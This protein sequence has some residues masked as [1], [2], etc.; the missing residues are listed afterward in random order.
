MESFPREI[1][2]LPLDKISGL[3]KN[4]PGCHLSDIVQGLIENSI[5]SSADE[6]IISIVNG[7][8]SSIKV[9]DNG[10]G[11]P[12]S[13][14]P[15][16][17]SQNFS[18]RQEENENF[19]GFS[20]CFLSNISCA[21]RIKI[22]TRTRNDDRGSLSIYEFSR[23]IGFEER[24]DVRLGTTVEIENFLYNFP[25]QRKKARLNPK[26][27]NKMIDTIAKYAIAYSW[28]KF[29]V[30]I[31]SRYVL[32][33][34][35]HTDFFSTLTKLHHITDPLN[36]FKAFNFEISK[37]FH[38]IAFLSS[39][40]YTSQNLHNPLY[41]R[42]IFLNGRLVSIPTIK[43]PLN[44]W[45][46][47]FKSKINKTALKLPYFIFIK[48]PDDRFNGGF[49]LSENT[50]NSLKLFSSVDG[51][52]QTSKIIENQYFSQKYKTFDFADRLINECSHNLGESLNSQISEYQNSNDI[53]KF[54]S[55]LF[56]FHLKNP[57][58]N[59]DLNKLLYPQ[60]PQSHLSLGLVTTSQPSQSSSQQVIHPTPTLVQTARNQSSVP[61]TQFKPSPKIHNLQKPPMKHP[62]TPLPP[63]QLGNVP[64]KPTVLVPPQ[65]T[66]SVGSYTE[67][68]KSPL[69]RKVSM[70]SPVI[71]S[72]STEMGEPLRLAV[73]KSFPTST[74]NSNMASSNAKFT[75]IN[76]LLSDPAGSS[77]PIPKMPV[78]RIMNTSQTNSQ[79]LPRTI[80]N[81]QVPSNSGPIK[82]ITMVQSSAKTLVPIKRKII[83]VK[84]S[85]TAV[86]NTATN[87]SQDNN[88]N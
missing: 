20:G 17:C 60:V 50:F 34:N 16:V 56:Q 81:N 61:T 51:E 78:T 26:E 11:I 57:P 42:A 10:H 52:D 13:S 68:H 63:Q 82:P 3:K 32:R 71:H 28:I 45:Y 22:E 35:G 48:Y 65:T 67:P 73:P 29:E 33:T 74:S 77:K 59:I 49:C 39:P 9:E 24:P 62:P 53:R 85:N 8:F 88:N 38:A 21:S 54:E 66:T 80:Q 1:T 2:R 25:G 18:S 19:F 37:D 58:K 27:E 87:H 4:S 12:R 6:I 7:G 70:L 40:R 43:K 69:T 14:I 5:D 30:S 84:S 15:V 41:L 47:E 23:M 75:D 55:S 36:Y 44:N 79:Q 76:N 64:P 83:S 46:D 86:N 72:S 31:N